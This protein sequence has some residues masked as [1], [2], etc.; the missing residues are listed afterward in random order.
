[1]HSP[2]IRLALGLPLVVAAA[3]GSTHAADLAPAR[4]GI[5]R[6]GFDNKVRP[7]DDFFRYVNGGWI[8]RTEIPADRP[9]YGASYVLRDK[10]ES[11]SRA[12]IEALAAKRDNPVGSDERKISDL[13][14][15]FM[16]EAR[17]DQLGM[18]PIEADSAR[19]DAITDKPAFLHALAEFQR[20][21]VTGLFGGFVS[22]DDKRSDRYIIYLNQSGLTLPDESYY[23]EAGFR[24]IREKFTTHV[25]KM[26]AL[27]GIPEPKSAAARVMA[28]ETSLAKHHLDRV[29]NRDRIR[30][31]NKF[32]RKGLD[33]LAPAIDWTAWLDRFGAPQVEE[34]VVRQPDYLAAMSK[35][36]G[37]VALD[38]WKLWLKWHALHAAAPFLSK[39]FVAENFAFFEHTLQGAL[40]I[41]PRW[42]RGVEV[43]ERGMG[44]ALGKIFVA[45]HFPPAA[46]TRINDL[47][48]NLIEAYREEIATLDWMSPETRTRALE[49]LAKFNAKIGYPDKWRDYSALQIGRDDLL[50]NVRATIAFEVARNLKKLGKPIDRGEWSM[51]PQTVNAYYNPGLNEIVFPAAILQPPLFDMEA[52]DAV[53]YGAIG[54]VIG[55][56]IGHGFDDQGSRSDGDGNLINWWTDP[57]R[58]QFEARTKML[59]DQYN[60]FEPAQ[61]PGKKVNGALTIGENIGDLG[62]LSIS[63]KAYQRSLK[64]RSAPVIE[65]LTGEERF[66]LGYAQAWQSKV[67]DAFLERQLATNPHSPAEFRC[68]GVLRNMPE[69]YAAFG[70][71]EGD[72]LWLPPE[73]RVRIW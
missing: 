34:L 5:D 71:K 52:D 17:A 15:S 4:S 53:N 47:V 21:G 64:G 23:R 56:E 6:S 43:V 35:L 9:S 54:A 50:A 27:A 51:T 25:E 45:K 13:Y 29:R 63:Y 44:E 28:V 61:L 58:K 69:F 24:P 65:A 36:L 22:T 32:D 18:K 30:T 40:E 38:D 1:M 31:Y 46:K 62:G 60:E 49:K 19:I 12:I 20:E 33:S 48:A 42:K 57:D 72:K 41:R 14:T 11:N 8:A 67:R 3:H 59:I 66:F 16:D 55:H 73:R 26:L 2:W 7:Q 39:P 37:E 70:V 68:N 10:S